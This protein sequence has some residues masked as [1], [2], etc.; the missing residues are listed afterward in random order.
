MRFVAQK[1]AAPLLAEASEEAARLPQPAAN[2]SS[3][4]FDRHSH[5]SHPSPSSFLIQFE[6]AIR[7]ELRRTLLKG[8]DEAEVPHFQLLLR[9]HAH[10][11]TIRDVTVCVQHRGRALCVELVWLM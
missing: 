1:S 6:E 9:A 2:L 8:E 4:F 7:E 11:T 3:F 5:P 10:A